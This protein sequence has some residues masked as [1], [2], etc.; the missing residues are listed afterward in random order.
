[1]GLFRCDWIRGYDDI[2]INSLFICM[3]K[4]KKLEMSVMSSMDDANRGALDD[5]AKE[6]ETDDYEH[7]ILSWE[8]MRITDE[9][10]NYMGDDKLLDLNAWVLKKYKRV[11]TKEIEAEDY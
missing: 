9:K 2:L 8:Q 5:N 3:I 10:M 11:V 6:I 7:I 4:D 1:M